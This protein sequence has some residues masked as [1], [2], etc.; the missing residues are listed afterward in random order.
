MFGCGRKEGR[1]TR[2][3]GVSLALAPTR[4]EPMEE[5]IESQPDSALDMAKK[6]NRRDLRDASAGTREPQSCIKT[7]FCPDKYVSLDLEDWQ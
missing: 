1:G 2:G 3:H 7:V 6:D 5:R 4:K